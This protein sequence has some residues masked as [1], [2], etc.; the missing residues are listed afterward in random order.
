MERKIE[1]R[2]AFLAK[3]IL[4]SGGVLVSTQLIACMSDDEPLL[5]N[6]DGSV[7]YHFLHGVGSFD[8]IATAVMIWT[9]FTPTEALVG[10][11]IDVRYE[12]SSST[13]FNSLVAE[14]TVQ[15]LP[16]HDYTV[17]V[18]VDSLSP[19]SKLYYRFSYQGA[20]SVIGETIT[21]PE[22]SAAISELNVAVCSCSNYPTGYFNVYDAIAK[23]EADVV[24]H[25]GDYIYEYGGA[26]SYG[27]NPL[28]ARPHD[29]NKEI[30][31]LEEYRK[32]Y[33]QYRTDESLQLA[34]QKKPFIVVWDDHEVANDAFKNGAENHQ[35]DEGSF[36]E[37]KA[38]AIKVHDEYLPVR[39]TALGTIYR[40][41]EFGSLLNLVMLDTRII[42]RDRQLA[43]ESFFTAEGFDGAGFAAA[44]ADS[45]RR[46]MGDAQLGWA[47]ATVGGSSA[48][49]Q[50]LGQQVLMGKMFFPAELLIANASAAAGQITQEQVLAL[51]AELTQ[52][53]ARA[54]QGD[55]S[56]TD[57]DL[58]RIGTTIP[59]NL[60]A[61]DGYFT[62]REMLFGALKG[63]KTVVFAGDTHNAWHSELR[64]LSGDKIGEEF[65][66]PSVTSPGLESYLALDAE[67]T[68]L[69]E[70]SWQILVDDLKYIDSS[71]RGYL[72]TKFTA[73]AATTSYRFVSTIESTAYSIIEGKS[74]SY[75]G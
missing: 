68:P 13:S 18:D 19:N 27:D 38:L 66:T 61:W 71:R 26:G 30:L 49:W 62:E 12:V 20:Q 46:L 2:R 73:G 33:R 9:R 8:P 6:P 75:S 32:R 70:Q 58:A 3:S 7:G 29:P 22:A 36:E 51:Q 11:A 24:L 65:A 48:T 57:T 43:L 72:L 23:S 67:S 60:D 15:A 14:G 52:L 40:N 17:M 53:K 5:V 50:V 63:K 55:P 69:L 44:M 56:L 10:Q 21:L 35:E 47:A 31:T 34:H 39:S 74:V 1:S 4:A 16:A 41:F 64:D 42:G 37:R 59:Y 45:T 54:L 25:L 28:L